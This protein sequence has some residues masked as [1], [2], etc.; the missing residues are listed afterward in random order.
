MCHFDIH[1][2][3]SQH[4]PF[5]VPDNY[6]AQFA[7]G[8]MKRLKVLQ[9]SAPIVELPIIRWLPLLGAACVAALAVLFTQVCHNE[10]Q[11]A[12]SHDATI[13]TSAASSNAD[14]A[15]DYLMLADANMINVYENAD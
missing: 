3:P 9:V 6:F 7:D 12:P 8:M 11:D 10:P 4:N 5:I 15:Y 13:S 14:V 1:Q 2:S